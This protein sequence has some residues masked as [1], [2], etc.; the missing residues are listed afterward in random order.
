MTKETQSS[1]KDSPKQSSKLPQDNQ[2]IMHP[3]QLLPGEDKEAWAKRLVGEIKKSLLAQ[4]QR[5]SSKA[6]LK[7]KPVFN[8]PRSVP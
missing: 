5:A 8:G 2:V 4:S 3:T 6:T 7:K 1:P